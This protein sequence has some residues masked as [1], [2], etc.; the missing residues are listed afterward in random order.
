M[1]GIPM[2]KIATFLSIVVLFFISIVSSGQSVP[3]KVS[4]LFYQKLNTAVHDLTGYDLISESEISSN[5]SVTSS[6]EVDGFVVLEVLYMDWANNAWLNDDKI[7]K[8]YNANSFLI[9]DLELDWDVDH[10]VNAAKM[11]YTNNVMGQPTE[12]MI[13]M[14]DPVEEDWIQVA[15]ITQNYDA[16]YRPTEMIS[17]MYYGGIWM[18]M[19]KYEYVY[20]TSTLVTLNAYEWDMMN[21]VWSISNRMV[22]NWN[23]ELLM[24]VLHEV[25]DGGEWYNEQLRTFTY[26]TVPC[27]IE[28]LHQLWDGAIWVNE[29][30]ETP[31]YNANWMEIERLFE[32]WYGS[33]ENDELQTYTYDGDGNLIEVLIQDWENKGWVNSFLES[34]TYGLVGIEDHFAN[35]LDP[36]EITCAPN[37]FNDKTK[38]TINLAGMESA[39]IEIYDITGKVVFLSWIKDS[40]D[41]VWYGTNLYGEQLDTG[42]YLMKVEAGYASAVSKI[43]I[44][45]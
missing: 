31:T 33:W 11:V 29:F 12:I 10:W 3:D 32:T 30:R 15:K 24:Q 39:W 43:S 38:I 13:Y 25:Y 8:T 28:E 19:I 37:P 1:G 14:W 6:Y 26:N 4:S 20:D 17:Q 5:K 36:I 27:C 34:Y 44:I 40:K 7:I 16:Q 9:E 41:F 21:N 18:N 23:G 2:K 42:I 35:R 45:R 22:Y